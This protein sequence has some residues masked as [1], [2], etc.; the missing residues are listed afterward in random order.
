MQILKAE[1]TVTMLNGHVLEKLQAVISD[2]TFEEVSRL[3]G[4]DITV[5]GQSYFAYGDIDTA[6][7]SAHDGLFIA[8]F[9]KNAQT[10]Y[11]LRADVDY[12]AIM[13]GVDLSV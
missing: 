7:Y 8:S 6:T 5:N 4:R 10:D 11:Q 2:A 1:E 9:L 13:T 3:N 12:I